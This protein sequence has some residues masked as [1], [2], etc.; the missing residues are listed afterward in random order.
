MLFARSGKIQDS[1]AYRSMFVALQQTA[2][3]TKHGPFAVAIAKR[4]N[5]FISTQ[6]SKTVKIA[7]LNDNFIRPCHWVIWSPAANKALVIS[8][9]EADALIPMIRRFVHVKDTPSS[10]THLIVYSAPVTRRML[11]FNNLDYH[12]TPPLPRKTKVPTWLKIELGIFSGKLYFEWSEYQALLGYLGI[13][14]GSEQE[15]RLSDASE[16]TFVKKP[17]TFCK[18]GS[19]TMYPET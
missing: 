13:T 4:S 6:F 14:M 10:Q 1:E 2:C 3:G 8:P 9:E 18:S 11:H 17:L 16:E 5:L 15:T 19:K 12:A 7:E